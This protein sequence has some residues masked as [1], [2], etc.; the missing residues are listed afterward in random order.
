MGSPLFSITEFH[1]KLCIFGFLYSK[2][3][4]F[5]KVKLEKSSFK[6]EKKPG[7]PIQTFQS[8]RIY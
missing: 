8:I 2:D 4:I 5:S 6:K 1:S 7:C 3:S